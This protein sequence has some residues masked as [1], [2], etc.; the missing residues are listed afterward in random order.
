V[1]HSGRRTSSFLILLGTLLLLAGLVALL[2]GNHGER[3]SHG[4]TAALAV[5][6]LVVA[7]APP[8]ALRLGPTAAAAATSLPPLTPIPTSG[9]PAERASAPRRI[10]IPKVALDAPVVEVGWQVIRVGDEMR[11]RWNTVANAVGHHRGSGDPGQ[12][13]NCVLSAHSSDAGG[14]LFRRLDEL[15]TGDTMDLYTVD[16]QR[17]TYVVQTL[18]TLDETS[19][20]ADEK[21]EHARWLDPTVEPVLTLVTCWPAW[22]YTHRLVVRASLLEG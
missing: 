6:P 10:L 22:S 5:P 16:G 12:R 19:A 20:T 21:R 2:L 3:P 1:I 17:Y 15:L 9:P 4:S 8:P 11:G 7:T 18:L 14:A 13:G